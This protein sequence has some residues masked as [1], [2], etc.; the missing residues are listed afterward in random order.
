ME[1]TRRVLIAYVDEAARVRV[2]AA[3]KA[4]NLRICGYAKTAADA[5]AKAHRTKPDIC[6]L[7][8]DLPGGGIDAAGEIGE[9]IPAV[10]VVVLANFASS[11]VS[12][13]AGSTTAA[14]A[15]LP[16]AS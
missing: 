8:L 12:W 16:L 7:D 3:A 11:G 1:R 15:E 4:A 9:Q 2:R 6:L 13:L 5:V 14:D 10:S